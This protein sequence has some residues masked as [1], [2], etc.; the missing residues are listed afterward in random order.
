MRARAPLV[1]LVV[2]AHLALVLGLVGP[3]MTVTLGAGASWVS[4]LLG[5]DNGPMTFSVMGGIAKLL[6]EQP[7]LALI[8]AL[9]SVVIPV[10]KLALM[11]AALAS[12]RSSPTLAKLGRWSSAISR[13]AFVDVLVVAVLI[14][15]GQVFPGGGNVTAEWGLWAFATAGLLCALGLHLLFPNTRAPVAGV[16]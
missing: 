9:C 11:T 5:R 7:A 13:F 16:G 14:V 8:V 4:R 6:E 12:P 10:A 3:M 1:V 2:L 15:G